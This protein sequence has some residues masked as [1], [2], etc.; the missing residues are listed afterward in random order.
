MAVLEAGRVTET[1]AACLVDAPLAEQEQRALDARLWEAAKAGDAAAVERLAGEGASA[2][3]KDEDGWPAV[4]IA[5]REGH[6]EVVEALLRLGC[7]PNAPDGGG[8]T[9]LMVAA[10]HGHG[11]VVSALLEHGGAELDAVNK[12]GATALMHAANG[13]HV[14]IA[15]QLV[16]AG[17]DATLRATGGAWEGKTALEI[18]ET[19]ESW[20]SEETKQGKAEVAALLRQR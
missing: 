4:V 12:N 20:D 1:S 13:G 18:A 17:A 6:T 11:G 2:D 10:I 16:E 14:A 9:A 3:A 19:T 15:A 7:D 8:V 5:A